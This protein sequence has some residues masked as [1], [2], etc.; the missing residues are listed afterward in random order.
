M[1]RPRHAH[2]DQ[3]HEH[4]VSLRLSEREKLLLE[5]LVQ[6]R[7]AELLEQTGEQVLLSTA[8][9][10]R[11]MILR[12]ARARGLDQEDTAAPT[13]TKAARKRSRST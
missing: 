1:P 12:E 3:V 8:S 9:I 4:T 10:I 11:S 6:A 13:A 2:R 7:R 5:R